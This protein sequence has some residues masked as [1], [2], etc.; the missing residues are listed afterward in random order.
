MGAAVHLARSHARDGARSGS[1]GRSPVPASLRRTPAA[2][3]PRARTRLR[4]RRGGKANVATFGA[5]ADDLMASL[6]NGWRNPKH[7]A[8]WKMTLSVYAAPLRDVPVDKI[9]T[10]DVLAVLKPLW[11]TKPE[12]ASRLRGRIERV[13]D[14]ARVRGLRQGENPA[15][16]ARTSR[17]PAAEAGKAH[18]GHHEAMA[19][20][21]CRLPE[22]C[23]RD[24]RSPARHSLSPS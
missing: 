23:R 22:R 17:S 4:E 6:E 5:G 2:S 3:W 1:T 9:S 14:A 7:R 15:R 21:A 8:Q 16:S 19:I 18:R 11:T 12:T 20:D 10:E 24:H 13:L